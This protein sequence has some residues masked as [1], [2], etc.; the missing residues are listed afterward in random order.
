MALIDTIIG[1]ESGG[2]RY[3]KNPRSSAYGPG[4]FITS[5]WLNMVRKYRPDL[6]AGRSQEQVLALRSDPAISR[7]M[8]DA[9]AR[10]N[11]SSLKAGGFEPTN[12]NVY[13]SHFAGP[14]GAI[15]LLRNPRAMASDVLSPSAIKANPFLR[16]WTAQQVIDWAGGKMEGGGALTA[17]SG[18]G[19]QRAAAGGGAAPATSKMGSALGGIVSASGYPEAGGLLSGVL[20]SLSKVGKSSQ[21]TQQQTANAMNSTVNANNTAAEQVINS[22]R[23]ALDATMQGNQEMAKK[24]IASALQ[25]PGDL[26]QLSEILQR[27]AMRG[28]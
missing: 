17:D 28:V 16:N 10:E 24:A 21:N 13:L 2:D 12:R 25:S 1:V 15:G 19:G 14:A 27:R 22:S 7:E 11:S 5:T 26:L 23:K 6:M 18:G 4:Q 8:T 9:Y 3:A 20:G